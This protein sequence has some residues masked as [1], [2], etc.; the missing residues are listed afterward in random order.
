MSHTHSIVRHFDISTSFKSTTCQTILGLLSSLC[1]KTIIQY[2]TILFSINWYLLRCIT[3]H[4]SLLLLKL[5]TICKEKTFKNFR[6]WRIWLSYLAKG[7]GAS[8][9]NVKR[10]SLSTPTTILVITVLIYGET[11]ITIE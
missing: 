11:P 4:F 2:Y 7:T 3:F 6:T 5:S 9:T 1:H 10:A 8:G